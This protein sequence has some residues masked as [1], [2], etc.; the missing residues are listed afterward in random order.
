M[1][2][3]ALSLYVCVR[4]TE[5]RRIRRRS[6]HGTI[7]FIGSMLCCAPVT[8]VPVSYSL[9]SRL[10]VDYQYLES[11]VILVLL[12]WMLDGKIRLLEQSVLQTEKEISGIVILRSLN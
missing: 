7:I 6:R 5:T 2:R 8:V 3:L 4:E 9:W 1:K 11:T 10:T 12:L